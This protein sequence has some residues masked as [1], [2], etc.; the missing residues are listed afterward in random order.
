LARRSRDDRTVDGW[1][2]GGERKIAEVEVALGSGVRTAGR[3][4]TKEEGVKSVG[5]IKGDEKERVPG[6][7]VSKGGRKKARQRGK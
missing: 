1:V 3:K 5:R 7:I 6:G 2:L 4:R